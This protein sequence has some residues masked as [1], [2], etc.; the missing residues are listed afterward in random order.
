MKAD[1]S[2]IHLET[3]LNPSVSCTHRWRALLWGG[4]FKPAADWQSAWSAAYN[5]QHGGLP[6]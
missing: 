3:P 4:L 5:G 2:S 1:A 6:T